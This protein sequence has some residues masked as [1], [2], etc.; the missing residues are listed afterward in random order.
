M[1]SLE[2][3][4]SQQSLVE[5]KGSTYVQVPDNR[6]GR[7]SSQVGFRMA[8]FENENKLNFTVFENVKNQADDV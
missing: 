7:H 1:K 2:R 3:F 5:I 6:T 8:V 4:K